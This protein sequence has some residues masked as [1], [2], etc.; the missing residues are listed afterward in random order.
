MEQRDRHVN[1]ES[2]PKKKGPEVN[3]IFWQTSL[4]NIYAYFD[5][6]KHSRGFTDGTLKTLNLVGIKKN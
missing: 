4:Y 1:L 5:Q 2:S 6:K 3:S